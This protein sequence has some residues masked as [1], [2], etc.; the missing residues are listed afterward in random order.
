MSVLFWTDAAHEVLFPLLDEVDWLHLR[1]H[2][3]VPEKKFFA[4]DRRVVCL[5]FS[6]AFCLFIRRNGS[7]FEARELVKETGAKF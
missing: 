4:F 3:G 5:Q 7:A 6:P 1:V 2:K